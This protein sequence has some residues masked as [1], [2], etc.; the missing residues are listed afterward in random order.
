MN[1]LGARRQAV[2]AAIA[3]MIVGTILIVGV[4]VMYV[5]YGTWLNTYGENE[6]NRVT[7]LYLLKA[8]KHLAF[9]VCPALAVLLVASGSCTLYFV[10]REKD[11]SP[12]ESAGRQQ[13]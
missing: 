6:P 8:I 3:A 10:K 11:Q 9:G 7:T 4:G 2:F 12:A 1:L 13:L 5:L